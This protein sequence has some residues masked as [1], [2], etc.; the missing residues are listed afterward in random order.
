MFPADDDLSHG[1]VRSR[2]AGLV[3]TLGNGAP[4]RRGLSHRKVNLRRVL[5]RI[6]EKTP[7]TKLPVEA[8]MDKPCRI[9]ATIHHFFRVSWY[10]C[11]KH[12]RPACLGRDNSRCGLQAATLGRLAPLPGV[13]WI[14]DC[15]AALWSK[16]WKSS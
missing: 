11:T 8:V 6:A 9:I 13:I 14:H 16:T 5:H 3:I 10:L 2:P 4:N 15:P 12:R 1:R 7:S